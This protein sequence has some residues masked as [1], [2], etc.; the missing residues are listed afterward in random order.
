MNNRL[1]ATILG[2]LLV[3]GCGT[4][5]S[6]AGPSPSPTAGVLLRIPWQKPPGAA[7]SGFG[8]LWIANRGEGTVSR[9]DARTGHV[10]ATIQVGN[11]AAL[12]PDCQLGTDDAAVGDFIVRRC[13]LPSGLAAGAGAV[14]VGRSD[15]LSVVRID[16]G[17]NLVTASIPVGA[18]A[19]GIGVSVSA[20]WVTAFEDDRVI[21]IDPGTNRVSLDLHVPHGPSG[22]AVEGQDAWVT[23]Y[24]GWSVTAIDGAMGRVRWTVPAGINPLPIAIAGGTLWVR[25]EGDASVWRIDARTGRVLATIPVDPFVGS[26]GLDNLAVTTA[27]VWAGGLRLQRIDPTANR[28][29]QSLPFMGW[30]VSAE[31]GTLWTL[32]LASTIDRVNPADHR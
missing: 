28:V 26:D 7:A 12:A 29:A 23:D 2:F 4:I 6:P 31:D 18:H 20:V 21:R 1:T 16:P 10:L 13:D 14:W 19:F 24:R 25:N 17:T 8:S 9:L 5:A 27:G 30:P 32:G 22:I 3:A 15:T 11:P